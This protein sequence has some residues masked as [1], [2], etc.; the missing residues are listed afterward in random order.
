M[1]PRDLYEILPTCSKRTILI[2]YLIISRL[3]DSLSHC[4]FLLSCDYPSSV[5]I[6]LKCRS[7]QIR[8][9]W[10]LFVK[11]LDF[12]EKI[13][14]R[15]VQVQCRYFHLPFQPIFSDFPFSRSS[16]H[17]IGDFDAYV[18]KRRKKKRKTR[19]HLDSVENA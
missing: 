5:L 4:S 16:R 6:I 9:F 3:S 17:K 10:G 15:I 18:E 7:T 8:L 1:L 14:E 13:G 12:L 2:E 19:W 11:E